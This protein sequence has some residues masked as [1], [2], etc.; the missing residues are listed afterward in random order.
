MDEK[1]K[2]MLIL[3]ALVIRNVDALN[4]DPYHLVVQSFTQKTNIKSVLLTKWCWSDEYL[5][6]LPLHIV[7]PC[8]IISNKPD[9]SK[10]LETLPLEKWAA[11]FTK[12]VDDVSSSSSSDDDDHQK[13]AINNIQ[14]MEDSD[15]NTT[16]SNIEIEA[17]MNLHEFDDEEEEEEVEDDEEEEDGNY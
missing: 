17:E 13:N 14:W 1:Q 16:N 7:G 12:P 6:I 5:V 10:I 15:D 9:M 2:H 3:A 11:E 8:F 4:P